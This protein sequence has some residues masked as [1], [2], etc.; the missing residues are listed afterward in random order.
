MKLPR[1]LK[2]KIKAAVLEGKDPLWRSREVRIDAYEAF[3]LHRT[4]GYRKLG[5]PVVNMKIVSSY[6][7]LPR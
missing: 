7:L 2:K 3:P 6:R 4:L 1:K 5:V